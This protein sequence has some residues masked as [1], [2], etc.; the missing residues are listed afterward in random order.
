MTQV[1]DNDINDIFDVPLDLCR[2]FFVLYGTR[3]SEEM[4][5]PGDQDWTLSTEW[6]P[7]SLNE[8]F[9]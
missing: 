7:S 1:S 3:M 2:T 4:L 8:A 6:D 5:L 9:R